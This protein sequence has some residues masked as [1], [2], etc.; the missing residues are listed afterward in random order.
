M[1]PLRFRRRLFVLWHTDPRYGDLWRSLR[2]FLA[3]QRVERHKA[4]ASTR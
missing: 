4:R 1:R 2:H 3:Q